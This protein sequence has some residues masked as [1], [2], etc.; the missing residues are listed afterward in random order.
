MLVSRGKPCKM[1]CVM[2]ERLLD[3]RAVA[4]R[5]SVTPYTV[6][7]W[8]NQ[9]RLQGV[10]MSSGPKAKWRVS[11]SAI[12]AFREALHTKGATGTN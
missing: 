8:L 1:P 2:D 4:E 12:R 6:R 7:E 11:E 10:K 5:F 3:V 9:G